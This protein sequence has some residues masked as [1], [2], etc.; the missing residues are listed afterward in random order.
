MASLRKLDYVIFGGGGLVIAISILSVFSTLTAEAGSVSAPKLCKA[1]IATIMGRSP[2]IINARGN[3]V[4]SV[5]Y[6]RGDGTFWDYKCR[7]EGNRIIW[8]APEGR[9][10]THRLDPKITFR[11]GANSVQIIETFSD[12]T[13]NKQSF[14]I[15]DL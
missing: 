2:D 7:V 15:S 8:G 12:G 14:S 11:T 3:S 9:W 10:R 4:I 1:A 5:D 13:S 6:T